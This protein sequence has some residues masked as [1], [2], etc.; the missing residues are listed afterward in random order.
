M[1]V[2]LVVSAM[3]ALTYRCVSVDRGSILFEEIN[4]VRHAARE[5]VGYGP[6]ADVFD[7]RAMSA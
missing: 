4:V 3:P 5:I 6:Q 1:I 7:V 2:L